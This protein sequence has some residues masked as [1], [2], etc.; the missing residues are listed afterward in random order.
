[1]VQHEPS[2]SRGARTGPVR[3][4]LGC[5]QRS[6]TADLLR[7]VAREVEPKRF[8]LVPDPERRLTGRGAWLHPDPECLSQAERRRAFGRALRVPGNPDAAAL[9]QLV[10]SG[11][12]ASL[13]VAPQ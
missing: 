3:T 7:I 12:G 11:D 8:V 6:L 4:C 9:V 1:M 5:R 2:S 10:G 13:G